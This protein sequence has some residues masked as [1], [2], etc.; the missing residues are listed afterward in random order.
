MYDYLI[1]GAGITGC[2]LAEQLAHLGR[3]II[4]VERRNHVGGNAYDEYDQYGILVHRYGPHI[5]RTNSKQIW[6]YL[7]RFTEW[8]LYQHQVRAYV[9][10]ITVP[11]PVNLDT[12]NLLFN[13]QLTSEEMRLYLEQVRQK[14]GIHEIK[15]A[16]DMAIS[17]VGEELYEKFFKY[18]TQKQ[19]GLWPEELEPEVTARIPV[20][21]NR[22]PRY[23]TERYQGIPRFGY[24]FMLQRM[25]DHANIHLLL[26]TDFKQ[27]IE[28]I[29]FKRM[30]Y[31]GPIDAFFDSVY[32]A[33]PY[34][35]LV[36]EYQTLPVEYYQEAATVN[37]P[38]DYDFTRISEFKHLTG[39]IH[40]WT[41]IAR[42]YPTSSGEPYYPIPTAANQE[43]YIRYKN[44]ADKLDSVHFVGRLA[45][46]R[47]FSMDQVIHQAF[48][49]LNEILK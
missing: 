24:T 19:W 37:Y 11:F 4:I 26:K 35:S 1:V 36:F 3:K 48:L 30:I 22:D 8:H 16:R 28:M 31:T 49:C 25:L 44:E 33:L 23:F 43:L 17:M 46:Y 13:F 27:I 2:V 39:Q 42:E 7:S 6:E 5:F 15:N 41:T 21:F 45:Q 10:G 47:Y 38:N 32:G 40:P 18:Y 9:D 14:A 34:R 29:R 20:R 12:V